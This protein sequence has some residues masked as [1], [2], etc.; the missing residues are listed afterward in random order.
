MFTSTHAAAGGRISQLAD[1]VGQEAEETR[2]LDRLREL[3]LL[4]GRH[5]RDPARHDLAALG[6]VTLKE[7]GV[8]VIDLRRVGAGERTSLAP[9]EEWPPRAACRRTWLKKCSKP[10]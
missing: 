7:L 1:H 9:P 5:R 8:L 3:A 6:N 2:A 10:C 4:L